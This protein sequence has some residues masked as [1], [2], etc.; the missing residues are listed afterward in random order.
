MRVTVNVAVAGFVVILLINLA[1]PAAQTWAGFFLFLVTWYSDII[2]SKKL[3][4]VLPHSYALGGMLS[5]LFQVTDNS[6]VLW[7]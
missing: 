5:F 6:A 7:L 3:H 4:F 1:A 2:I